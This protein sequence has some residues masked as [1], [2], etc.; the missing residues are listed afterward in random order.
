MREGGKFPRKN[1]G[2]S[3]EWPH[4]E[5]KTLGNKTL[6]FLIVKR[7][8]F[9]LAMIF[10]AILILLFTEIV[11]AEYR[12][13]AELT[14]F[15]AVIAALLAIGGTAG[16]AFLEYHNYS[17]T[18][19]EKNI[20]ITKGILNRYETGIP[21]RRVKQVD[22]IRTIVCRFFGISNIIITTVGEEDS[23]HHSNEKI[24]LPYLEKHLA[25]KIQHEIL[26]HAQVEQMRMV[27]I[28]AETAG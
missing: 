2:K 6:G 26:Q 16:V 12:A 19:L 28:P 8:G 14:D 4:M 5:H 15:F 13:Y 17:I 27:K 20:R 22:I 3:V 7:S 11:P 1:I 10:A 9:M 21:Y 23:T 24:S 18:I 25:E